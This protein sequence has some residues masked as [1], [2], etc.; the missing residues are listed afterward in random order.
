MIANK[1]DEGGG[2]AAA[3]CMSFVCSLMHA[4][5]LDLNA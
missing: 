3:L 2:V 1:V 5:Q 4:H